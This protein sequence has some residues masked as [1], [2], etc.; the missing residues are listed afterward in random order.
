LKN[1]FGLDERE[2]NPQK[3]DSSDEDHSTG[4]NEQAVT[5][6]ADLGVELSKKHWI[7]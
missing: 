3:S 2:K 4:K 5:F 7:K 1:S 6:R